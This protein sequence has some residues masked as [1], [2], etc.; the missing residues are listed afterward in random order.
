MRYFFPLSYFTNVV[1]KIK[2]E[3]TTNSVNGNNHS[4]CIETFKHFYLTE[5]THFNLMWFWQSSQ[6]NAVFIIFS[7]VTIR[8]LGLSTKPL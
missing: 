1:L 7:C 2:T 3:E 8:P 4:E 6:Q 5:T